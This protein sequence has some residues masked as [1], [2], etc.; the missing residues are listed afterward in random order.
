LTLIVVV[1]IPTGVVLSGDSR[2]TLSTRQQITDPQN[3][4]N[5]I[6]LQT[7]LV[8][9]DAA[10]KVFDLYDKYGLGT[11]GDAL[12]N[13][14]PIAHYV[15]EFLNQHPILPTSTQNLAND[16][17]TYF[18]SLQPIPNASFFVVGYDA[19]IPFVIGV[20]VVNN[21]TKRWNVAQN[22]QIQY[23]ILRGGDTA[24]VDRLLSQPQF[25]PIFPVMNIQDAVDYSRHLIRTTIDEMRFE[26]RFSTVGGSIDTLIVAN[27]GT[28]FLVEKTL[29][30]VT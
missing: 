19:N 17:L 12:V 14:L 27:Q 24:I 20:E 18:R 23:G 4:A 11:F 29:T 2:T 3:P 25:N 7:D 8:L 9:S 28:K 10:N 1:Y 6:T 30:F 13:N 5:Q 22:N 21:H 15:R 26:P 16:L